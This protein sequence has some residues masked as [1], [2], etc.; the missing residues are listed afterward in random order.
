MREPSCLRLGEG[1]EQVRP[2]SEFGDSRSWSC[3][4]GGNGQRCDCL[5]GDGRNFG[6]AGLGTVLCCAAP[7]TSCMESSLAVLALMSQ[8]EQGLAGLD[9][10]AVYRGAFT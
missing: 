7:V 10:V 8:V 5:S 9:T 6:R 1:G 2:G 3:F 4:Q